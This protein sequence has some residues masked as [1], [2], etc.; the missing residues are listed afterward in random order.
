MDGSA[1]LLFASLG[2]SGWQGVP[3]FAQAISK[4]KVVQSTADLAAA[5]AESA[6]SKLTCNPWPEE[7]RTHTSYQRS[8]GFLVAQ[9]R[10]EARFSPEGFG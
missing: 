1:L 8:Q 7:I 3:I 5:V 2:P 10:R 9:P 6:L 4:L